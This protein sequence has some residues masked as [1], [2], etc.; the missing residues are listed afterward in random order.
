L[1]VLGLLA[2]LCAAQVGEKGHI[3]ADEVN[4]VN[5]SALSN[6][7]LAAPITGTI[8]LN[9][10]DLPPADVGRIP[11]GY[12]GL[13][14]DSSDD[15]DPKF[16]DWT[17][18][19]IDPTYSQPHSG[20]NYLFNAFGRN[21]VGFSLPAATDSLVG[22]WFAKTVGSGGTPSQVRF[23]GYDDGH[24]IVQQSA[25]LTLAST[26]RYLE[27]NFLPASNR[28]PPFNRG[29]CSLQHGRFDV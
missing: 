24:V 2:G 17:S 27:A 15:G 16:W 25:W 26:P 20:D 4:P 12:A 8:I 1:V 11:S 29:Q 18:E 21:D 19:S 5:V 3:E 22:A 7:K 10:D 9:F 14:W 13:E 28:G 6:L 23:N